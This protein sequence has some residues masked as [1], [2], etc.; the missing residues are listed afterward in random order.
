MFEKEVYAKHLNA[1]KATKNMRKYIEI[2]QVPAD[3]FN[4][5]NVVSFA[6]YGCFA[7]ME[8][9][10]NI[11]SRTYTSTSGVGMSGS[12]DLMVEK[13]LHSKKEFTFQPKHNKM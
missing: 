2:N 10:F 11:L 13:E 7:N 8:S 6:Y 3:A 5:I 12:E 1:D 4:V 9:S